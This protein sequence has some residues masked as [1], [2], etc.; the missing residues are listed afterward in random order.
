M[1]YEKKVMENTFE[2]LT[3]DD[4]AWTREFSPEMRV[5]LVDLLLT[6]FKDIEDY[7]RCAKLQPMLDELEMKNENH[8]KTITTGS[9]K[10]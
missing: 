9:G 3:K 5:Q 6:Y 8:N 7:E 4:F 1:S 2:I 10:L